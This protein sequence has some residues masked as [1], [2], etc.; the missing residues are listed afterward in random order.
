MEEEESKTWRTHDGY[1]LS[2]EVEKEEIRDF[3]GGGRGKVRR[4]PANPKDEAPKAA[5]DKKIEKEGE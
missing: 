2:K 1:K 5:D 4:R 3:F